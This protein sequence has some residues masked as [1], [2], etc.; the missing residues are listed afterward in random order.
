VTE[1]LCLICASVSVQPGRQGYLM[2]H[3]LE[4]ICQCGDPW[5]GESSLQPTLTLWGVTAPWSMSL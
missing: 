1:R 2:V 4:G 3:Y 5:E